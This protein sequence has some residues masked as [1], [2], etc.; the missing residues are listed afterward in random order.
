MHLT[1][2]IFHKPKGY[3]PMKHSFFPPLSLLSKPPFLIILFLMAV[4][5]FSFP[6]VAMASPINTKDLIT[7]TE[8]VF[9]SPEPSSEENSE[10]LAGRQAFLDFFG[11][12]GVNQCLEPENDDDN[13][14]LTDSLLLTTDSTMAS[15]NQQAILTN[16]WET[17]GGGRINRKYL[18]GLV[19]FCYDEEL[20][21]PSG[22]SYIY[23]TASDASIT[24]QIAAIAQRFG[25][26]GVDNA[27][28]WN[29]CQVA[30]WAARAGCHSYDSAAAFA[31][32]YCA[33]RKITD[34]ATVE[35]YA[36]IVGAL[37]TETAGANDTAYLYQAADPANQRILTYLCVWP[38]PAPS[39]PEPSY[40]SPQYDT[41]SVSEESVATAQHSI[42]LDH[43][44]AAITGESL[45]GAVFTVCEDGTAVATITTDAQGQGACHWMVTESSSA[46]ILKEYCSNYDQLDPQLRG[47]ISGYTNREDAYQAARS[48]A[49]AIA[50]TQA[51]AKINQPRRVTITETTVPKGFSITHSAS[52]TITLAGDASAT[53]SVS[54]RPWSAT[55][56]IHKADGIT[57]EIITSDAAFTLYEW[58]GSDYEISPH[59]HIFRQNDGIYTVDSSYTDGESG[60]LYYTQTNQGRFALAETQAPHG[61][62]RDP[63]LWYF[64]IESDGQLLYGHNAFPGDY[65][66][67]D[68]T[69]F[70]N[71]PKPQPQYDTVSATAESTA[72]RIHQII[73]DSKTAA[74]TGEALA[75]AVFQICEEGNVVGTITTDAQGQGF[76]QWQLSQSASATVTKEYCSNFHQLETEEQATVS[77]FTSRDAALSAAQTEADRQAKAMADALADQPRTVTVEEI[78]VPLGFSATADSSQ[79]LILTGPASDDSANA[80]FNNNSVN[81]S[82]TASAT[83]AAANTPWS[84][85]LLIHKADGTTGET[86]SSDAIFTLYEWNGSDYQVSPHYKIHRRDDGIYTATAFYEGSEPGRL[87]YTQQNQGKFAVAETQAP[88]GYVLDD[89]WFYFEITENDQT[90]WAHNVQP[91]RYPIADDTR[92]FNQSVTGTIQITKTGDYLT[93]VEGSHFQYTTLPVEG[94]SFAIYTTKD[95][96]LPDGSHQIAAYEDVCLYKGTLITTITTDTNG[97][98]ILEGLP[99]GTYEIREVCVGNG[100][101]LLDPTVVTVTLSYADQSTPV[102]M[103]DS[104]CYHNQRQQ[105]SLSLIKQNRNQQ[106]LSGAIFG[107]YAAEDIYG[108]VPTDASSLSAPLILADTLVETVTTA[109]DGTAIFLSS[110]PCGKY[111]I[112]ELTPPDGYLLSEEIFP[113]DASYTGPDGNAILSFVHTFIDDPI[114]PQAPAFSVSSGIPTGDDSPLGLA[115]LGLLSSLLLIIF[116]TRHLPLTF[117]QTTCQSRFYHV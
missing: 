68:P 21:F 64:S 30:I 85:T 117:S 87:Y 56:L 9:L 82:Y 4:L 67:C 110:L 48:E 17:V 84:A 59:Y 63:E 116:L 20:A 2:F 43:K 81:S 42:L 18:N 79:S 46:T 62:Y 109:L 54:N 98:A 49:A 90:I 94:A 29:E 25:R 24:G 15:S 108:Y 89:E 19:A 32:S 53:I 112:R 100:E 72:I 38:D 91:D 27:Q 8:K 40:P 36:H 50:K 73:L 92:F 7:S 47:S 70:A 74:V 97:I 99:L 66:I 31:R 107:L 37:I 96:L 103:D 69:K 75:G 12:D 57:G 86:I 71:R 88:H 102:V 83:I 55:L 52:Q 33:D 44:S 80:D 34:P 93:G 76:C 3:L 78:T 28:W 61:Y 60:R 10:E 95:I 35:D 13:S 5:L 51:E 26:S 106:A 58:N 16:V 23:A 105:I 39:E 1:N 65:D 101:F 22:A 111:Y 45:S 114:P 41:V 77:G 14:S 11:P 113:I 115:C 104:A 6:S